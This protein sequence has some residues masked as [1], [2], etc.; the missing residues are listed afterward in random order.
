MNIVIFIKKLIIIAFRNFN[1]AFTQKVIKKLNRSILSGLQLLAIASMA[2][3]YSCSRG[4]KVPPESPTRGNIRIISDESF[5]PIIE[6]E[7][8][9]FTQLY[10]NARIH[11]TY[12]PEIDVINDFM[13]DSVKVI[14]TSKKLTEDQIQ[15]LRDTLVIARTQ[16]FAYDALTLITNKEN[17]DTLLKYRDVKNIFLGQA[18]SWE[19]INPKSRL[20]E[21]KVV[22]DNTKSGNIRYFKELFEIKTALPYNFYALNSN[23]DVVDYVSRNKDALG[24]ISVNWIS[25]RDD[26]L[27]RSFVRRV[28]VVGVSQ[29]MDDASYYRPQQGFIYDKS[30]PFVREIYL[31]SRETFKGLGSGFIAW[32]AAEQGQR[33]VLKAGL[34]PATMPIRIVQIKNE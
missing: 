18:S 30:Y 29:P 7:V 12:K 34:V 11:A 28:N 16:I 9:T 33:I 2:F 31:I 23:A 24:I 6:A 15:Y 14:V 4:P 25:D 22:F 21:I 5:Q 8:N 26:S 13:N 3:L 1:S 20:G 10:A 32:A 27:G 17:R 19:D